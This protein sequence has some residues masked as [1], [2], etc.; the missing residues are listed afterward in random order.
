[1]ISLR[2]SCWTFSSIIA[3]IFGWFL[4]GGFVSEYGW[5]GQVSGMFLI[6][7][8][9][10]LTFVVFF[11]RVINIPP[12]SLM[13]S[14]GIFLYVV[15]KGE[16]KFVG[17][18]FSDKKNYTKFKLSDLFRRY[19]WIPMKIVDNYSIDVV[20]PHGKIATI[21]LF[22]F[23]VIFNFSFYDGSAREAIAL[24]MLK[25]YGA[26]YLAEEMIK[27]KINLALKKT[28]SDCSYAGKVFSTFESFDY[29]FLENC[30]EALDDESYS[31][32]GQKYRT[33]IMIGN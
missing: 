20:L 15:K 25:K 8:V 21:K 19:A 6:T 22:D 11:F 5:C 27:S 30:K 26:G 9:A 29:L 24:N 10:W 1:M 3:A 7:L 13:R 4:I 33:K 31:Y 32:D 18:F 28:F 17:E 16:R 2:A 23:G 14:T 12:L